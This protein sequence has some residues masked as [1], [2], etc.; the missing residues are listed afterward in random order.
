MDMRMMRC[1]DLR[2]DGWV[3]ENGYVFIKKFII[4]NRMHQLRGSWSSDVIREF[5]H[6]C[7]RLSEEARSSR[8]SSY[9]G[10]RTCSVFVS[11]LTADI[12]HEVETFIIRRR[13]IWENAVMR[14]C[15]IASEIRFRAWR[16]FVIRR[17]IARRPLTESS[18]LIVQPYHIW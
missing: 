9:F 2:V 4:C 14:R 7:G 18:H 5:R 16:S 8:K 3:C 12:I 17:T 10:P 6:C 1:M 11:A 15:S 13:F